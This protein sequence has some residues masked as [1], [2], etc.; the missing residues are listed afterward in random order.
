M[1]DLIPFLIFIVIAGVNV[2]KYRADK[3]A[4]KQS[5]P[6]AKGK[7]AERKP[8]TLEEFFSEIAQ[9][10]EP[11]AQELPEWPETIERPDYV[12]QMQEYEKAQKTPEPVI[13]REGIGVPAPQQTTPLP[14]IPALSR[15]EAYQPKAVGR[16]MS[17]MV[18]TQGTLFTG[19]GGQ[20]ISS[21][22]LLR[23]STGRT[24]FELASKK[25]LKRAILAN[26]V[27][28]PPRA[29]ETSF[30]NTMAE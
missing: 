28:G 18:P 7:Q 12:T 30:K 26:M 19:L 23:S 1:E 24:H 9:K 17:N 3:N 21:P 6:D 4:K 20:R 27:F 29:Y 25:Q 16:A 11:K 10:F 2:L 13:E 5:T 8:S 22:P 14:G 15:V